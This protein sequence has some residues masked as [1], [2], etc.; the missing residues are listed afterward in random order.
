M[1]VNKVKLL[2]TIEGP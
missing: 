1:S 2:P